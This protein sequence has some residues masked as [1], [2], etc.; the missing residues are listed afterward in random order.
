MMYVKFFG[1]RGS[2]PVPGPQ[3]SVFG[4]NTTCIQIMAS[5][6]K[7][8]GVFDAGTGIRNLGNSF[9]EY[10][11]GQNDIFITFSHFHWDHIQGF[12][13]FA[14]AY[15]RNIKINVLAM[16]GNRE[17]HNLKDIFDLQMQE[18]Y[19]PVALDEMGATFEFLL[20]KKNEEVFIPP[21][22]IPVKL[23]VVEHDHPG[24]CYSYRY[25]RLGKSLVITTDIENG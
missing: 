11:S 7:R 18:K 24:G 5:E 19:F 3:Y 9:Y 1:T 22:Q 6:T 21:D 16:G 12:P 25:Q 14:P 15:D 17:I 13:F 23:K 2:I 8:I 10:D 20:V 4:G